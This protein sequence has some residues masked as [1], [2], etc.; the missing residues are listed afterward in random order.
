M[1]ALHNCTRSHEW[2]NQQQAYS[3]IRARR[4]GI[5][6]G[7][8]HQI[9][10]AGLS[11]LDG[12]WHQIKHAGLSPFLCSVYSLRKC[13][14]VSVVAHSKRHL[15][16]LQTLPSASLTSHTGGD[17]ADKVAPVHTGHDG[18]TDCG[19]PQYHY[20]YARQD[21]TLKCHVVW[22][23]NCVPTDCVVEQFLDWLWSVVI[24][25]SF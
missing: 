22:T 11:P 17:K 16:F 4:R 5:L 10:H 3:R 25:A 2:V 8:W 7:W 15:L 9:K 14:V 20:S 12:W 24:Q 23:V 21:W 6:D 1:I 19:N 13:S 18:S